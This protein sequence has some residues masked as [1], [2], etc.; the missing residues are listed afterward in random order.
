MIYLDSSFVLAYL[1]KEKQYDYAKGILESDSSLWSSEL[2]RLECL[3]SICKNFPKVAQEKIKALEIT[4]EKIECLQIDSKIYSILK[5]NPELSYL[6]TLDAI[7]MA[8]LVLIQKETKFE[9][10][11][12]SFDS[13][14]SS[15]AENLKIPILTRQLISP[16]NV[17]TP[18]P[19]PKKKKK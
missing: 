15:L 8:S 17:S 3:V 1:F 16:S 18:T 9:I 10:T 6:R 4:L 14:M 13:R 11:L 12:A 19:K 5:S 7:H 2:L